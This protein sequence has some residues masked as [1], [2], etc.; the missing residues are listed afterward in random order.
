MPEIVLLTLTQVLEILHISRMTLYRHLRAGNL[1]HVK[2][3]R[4]VLFRKAD[5]EKFISSNVVK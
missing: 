1:P 2:I 3:G 4:R 5:V